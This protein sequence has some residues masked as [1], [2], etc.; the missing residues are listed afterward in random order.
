MASSITNQV[1]CISEVVKGVA[2]GDLSRMVEMD[3]HGEMLDLK[4]VLNAMV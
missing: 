4:F 1:R 2:L 3:M